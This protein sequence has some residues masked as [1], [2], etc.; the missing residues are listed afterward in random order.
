MERFITRLASRT[1][2]VGVVAA[3]CIAPPVLSAPAASA[4]TNRCG[5]PADTVPP[6]VTSLSLSNSTVNLDHGSRVVAITAHA[7]DASGNGAA[8]GVKRIDVTLSSGTVKLTRTAGT[9]ADGTWAGDYVVSKYGPTGHRILD[10]VT[11]ADAAGNTNYLY[12]A[13][14]WPHG[15]T[16]TGRP[17][18]PLAAGTLASWN[19]SPTTLNATKVPKTLHFK[20]KISGHQP[21]SVFAEFKPTH[22]HR[23]PIAELLTRHAGGV[24]TGTRRIYRGFG[25]LSYTP[26]IELGFASGLTPRSRDYSS[27]TL[28]SRFY[29]HGLTV[30]STPYNKSLATVSNLTVSRSS[31]D[32]T[33]GAKTVRVK[34]TLTNPKSG[35]EGASVAYGIVGG[36]AG[37]GPAAGLYLHP[38][39]GYNTDELLSVKMTRGTG[40]TWTGTAIIPRC[41]PT[42]RWSIGVSVATPHRSAAHA[43]IDGKSGRPKI[44]QVTSTVTDTVAPAF[45]KPTASS[46][47]GTISLGFTEGVKNVTTSD[48]TA[49]S[50]DSSTAIPIT[51]ITCA[52]GGTAADCSGADGLVTSA[53]LTVPAVTGHKGKEFVIEANQ[54]SIASQLVDG[55]GNPADWSTGAALVTA[56]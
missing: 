14:S 1:V 23:A 8:S 29:D 21:S 36:N 6:K 20:A 52:S 5:P 45:Y 39:V 40:N 15:I 46:T 19:F 2:A 4:T 47:N 53:V 50:L 26:T 48:L 51:G 24:W 56:K 49:R 27:N 10:G 7:T 54:D 25:S 43:P 17:A 37:G 30:I 3:A 41:V 55:V 9:A 34:A 16:V 35:I 32:T 11:I 12:D 22:G 33:T 28:T 38:G 31:V 42:G 44:I 13:T 18:K